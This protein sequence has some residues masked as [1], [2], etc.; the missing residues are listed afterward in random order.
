VVYGRPMLDGR[1]LTPRLVAWRAWTDWPLIVL[2]VGSLPIL[3]LEV[4]RSDLQHS[5]RVLIDVVNVVLLVAFAVDYVVELALVRNRSSYVRHE[6]TSLAIVLAQAIALMPSLAAFGV[7]RV[8][9][10]ARLFRIISVAIRGAAIG[11]SVRASGRQ[12]VREHAAALAF[13]VAGLTWL[14]SAVAFTL[15]EDVGVGGRINSFGDALW[16]SA[17]TITTVG[18]GDIYPVT[19]AGRIIGVFTM[20]VGVSVFALV[21][22]KLAQFLVREPHPQRS[23]D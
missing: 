11:G 10:G 15:A 1:H 22:A 5:D 2:A 16:W 14:T 19:T 7:L 23:A 3:L 12:L 4:E 6:W 20:V 18:Y 17:C 13:G 9:R 21:T 8:L